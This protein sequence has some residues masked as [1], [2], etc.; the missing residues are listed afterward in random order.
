MT[1][2][3]LSVQEIARLATADATDPGRRHMDACARCSALAMAYDEFMRATPADGANVDDANRRLAAFIAARIENHPVTAAGTRRVPRRRF[4][5]SSRRNLAF[6][7]AAA[8][9]VIAAVTVM[10]GQFAPE[11]M[12]LRGPADGNQ[13]ATYTV[14][15][16]GSIPLIWAPVEGADAYRIT[17]LSE[18]LTEVLVIGP[19]EGNTFVFEPAAH[20]LK[21][22]RY[23]W[24][25]TALAHGDSVGAVGPAPL[26]V[27]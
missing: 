11:P 1:K 10:R 21:S 23:F 27:R 6:A 14:T 17:I 20:S 4:E 9:L 18:E 5:F 7:A 12:V 13:L 15:V 2:N 8:V 24:E 3:C 22:G 19:I 16:G 25:V 26:F